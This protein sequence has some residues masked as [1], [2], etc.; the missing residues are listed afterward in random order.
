MGSLKHLCQ[1]SQANVL[2]NLFRQCK[3]IIEKGISTGEEELLEGKEGNYF[4]DGRRT[5]P[6]VTEAY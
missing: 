2:P 3:T 4:R 5:V 6:T 1:F